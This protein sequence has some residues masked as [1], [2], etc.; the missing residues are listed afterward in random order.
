MIKMF[1][2]LLANYPDDILDFLL[3]TQDEVLLIY[4][5]KAY[6]KL[7]STTR[8]YKDPEPEPINPPY[9]IIEE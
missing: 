6:S 3:C 9:T 5:N 4:Y 1:M 2:Y 7:M 8:Y